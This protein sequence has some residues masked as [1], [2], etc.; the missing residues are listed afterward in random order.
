MA[1][2][3][4]QGYRDWSRDDLSNQSDSQEG[5]VSQFVD[6]GSISFGRFA[7]E[8]LS[9]EKWSVFSHNRCQEELDKFKAPGLV[10]Q[11]KAYFEEYYKK[12]RALKAL[13]Q[14]QQA[15]PGLDTGGNTSVCGQTGEEQATSQ[16]ENTVEITIEKT[17]CEDQAT[18]QVENTVEVTIIKTQSEEN[19]VGITIEKER[20]SR[21]DSQLECLETDSVVSYPNSLRRTGSGRIEEIRQ[22]ENECNDFSDEMIN[23]LDDC[24]NGR[25]EERRQQ[26]DDCNGCRAEVIVREA[27]SSIIAFKPAADAERTT[28]KQA[29]TKQRLSRVTPT[30][31]FVSK[32]DIS[33]KKGKVQLSVQKAKETIAD[34]VRND[35]KLNHRAKANASISAQGLKYPLHRAAGK[36]ENSSNSR[37]PPTYRASSKKN[38][39]STAN[40]TLVERSNIHLPNTVPTVRCA[41]IPASTRDS[42]LGHSNPK[43]T[44]SNA[45]LSVR[46]KGRSNIQNISTEVTIHR[47]LRNN[48]SRAGRSHEVVSKSMVLDS[49]RNR[50]KE[51][52]A[53]T[54]RRKPIS[55]KLPAQSKSNRRGSLQSSLLSNDKLVK[56]NEGKEQEVP[57][58]FGQSSKT[59]PF[60]LAS[61][62]KSR[63]LKPDQNKKMLSYRSIDLTRSA[64]KSRQ[65]MPHWR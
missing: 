19:I 35:V 33:N 27:G 25:T 34:S 21:D 43:A 28:A 53:E 38:P 15:G 23:K 56:Q 32:V 62:S 10:A 46:P 11:K 60:T 52:D 44:N 2:D 63:I 48:A 54:T 17:Q 45:R 57:R 61:S 51:R 7:S 65:E 30:S 12:I 42:A 29:A 40:R 49:L 3:M 20:D 4:D 31:G 26:D 6:N 22:L 36:A 8:S 9:W 39:I 47:D 13:Q 64:G 14:D 58:K 24:S 1:T 5:S 18:S 55:S 37:N 59:G 16:V 41:N 50:S